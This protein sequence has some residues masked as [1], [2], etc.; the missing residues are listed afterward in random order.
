MA[1][2]ENPNI[3]PSL[4]EQFQQLVTLSGNPYKPNTRASTRRAARMAKETYQPRLLATDAK[5]AAAW[6]ALRWTRE[7]DVAGRSAFYADRYA[8]IITG[9]FNPTYWTT[10]ITTSDRTEL[11]YPSVKPYPGDWNPAYWDENRKPTVC[12]YEFIDSDYTTPSEPGDP[13]SPAPGWTG[14]VIAAYWQDEWHAQR[15]LRF[16]LPLEI[17][18]AEAR[19]ILFKLDLTIEADASFRG[20]HVWF[21]PGIAP[22]LYKA[23]GENFV[24]AK[25]VY[26]YAR[27]TRHR[28]P[29]PEENLSGWTHIVN[30]QIIRSIYHYA[31]IPNY[32][33][34]NRVQL[35]ISTTP[36]LGIYYSRNDAA[37]VWHHGI[38]QLYWPK[39]P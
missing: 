26:H 1:T 32:S 19:P 8:E 12:H 39:E 3:P 14:R 30:T 17:A 16:A 11:A 21:S 29:L 15:R 34:F 7:T 10:L 28:F 6:L 37:T 27:D 20:N 38:C 25:V 4:A 2:C 9:T 33:T 24:P 31:W 35:R 22:Y 5:N 18:I 13:D 23:I 36:S